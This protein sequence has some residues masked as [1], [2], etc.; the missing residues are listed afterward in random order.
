CKALSFPIVSGNVSLYNETNDEAILPTPVIGGVGLLRNLER[1]VDIGLRQPTLALLLVGGDPEATGWLGQSL[2]ARLI[3]QRDDDAPPPVDL[4]AERRTGDLIRRLINDGAVAACH[5]IS[6]GGVITCIV[7]MMLAGGQG[8]SITTPPTL[9]G[10][11]AINGWLFGED[12][13]R[14]IVATDAPHQVQEQAA[15]AAV[16]AQPIGVSGGD[17]LTVDG[18]EIISTAELRVLNEVW[19][20]RYMGATGGFV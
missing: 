4:I 11:P 8:A 10:L 19:L 17:R 5:D 14:Y 20:P 12:Q 15:A 16:A 18:T 13:G 1:R 9:D 2:F 6:E 3:M 7:E